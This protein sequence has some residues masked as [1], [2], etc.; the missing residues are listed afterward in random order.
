MTEQLAE[1]LYVYQSG[2]EQAQEHTIN[3]LRANK[4][5]VDAYLVPGSPTRH[6]KGAL[7]SAYPIPKNH[8]KIDT[9]DLKDAEFIRKH[10][11]KYD[12]MVCNIH[13]LSE[14][15]RFQRQAPPKY[16][17]IDM[18]HDGMGN[19][20]IISHRSIFALSFQDKHY[21]YFKRHNI[22]TEKVRWYKLDASYPIQV[23][24]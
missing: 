13:V 1:I 4:C 5:N 21:I 9:F 8:R 16:G 3:Y 15:G 17:V 18:E 24:D 7:W 10:K 22:T 23:D 19:E 6:Y 2:Q 11:N 12:F 20:A 14:M